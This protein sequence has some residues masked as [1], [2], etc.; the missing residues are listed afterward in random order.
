LEPIEDRGAGSY[1]ITIADPAHRR[2]FEATDI[3]R[4]RLHVKW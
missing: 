3:A 4:A 1:A 2:T